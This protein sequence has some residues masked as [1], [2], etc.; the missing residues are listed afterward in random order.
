VRQQWDIFTSNGTFVPRCVL[1]WF[2]RWS[3]SL[4]YSSHSSLCRA[5]VKSNT[6]LNWWPFSRKP[7]FPSWYSLRRGLSLASS[8]FAADACLSPRF[9]PQSARG[10][11]AVARIVVH[12]FGGATARSPLRLFN[13]SCAFGAAPLT[14]GV[15]NATEVI[16]PGLKLQ[17]S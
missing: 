12:A 1:C 17:P 13:F 3:S 14:R 7:R 6:T 15:Y 10:P 2:R 11:A 8:L 4:L 16:R 5:S 9:G